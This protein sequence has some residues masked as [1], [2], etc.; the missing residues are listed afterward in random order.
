MIYWQFCS[1]LIFFYSGHIHMIYSFV[2]PFEQRINQWVEEGK[3]F[4]KWGNGFISLDAYYFVAQEFGWDSYTNL[5]KI[6]Y[7]TDFKVSIIFL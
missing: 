6:Y 2:N 4:E 1:K 7:H 5:F 3:P